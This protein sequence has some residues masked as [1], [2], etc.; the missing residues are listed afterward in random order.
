MPTISDLRLRELLQ[1]ELDLIAVRAELATL[2]RTPAAVINTELAQQANDLRAELTAVQR[3]R[4]EL[5]IF[6]VLAAHQ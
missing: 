1:H 5:R 4:D 3:E 2:R 6:I